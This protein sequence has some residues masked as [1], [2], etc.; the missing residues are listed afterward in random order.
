MIIII[1]I[2]IFGIFLY[3]SKKINSEGL[4]L[5][6]SKRYHSSMDYFGNSPKDGRLFQVFF[7]SCDGEIKQ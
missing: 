7:F 2:Q 4:I 1:I 5:F 6:D 3:L